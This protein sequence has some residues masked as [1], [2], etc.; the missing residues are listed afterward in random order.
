MKATQYGAATA[1][2]VTAFARKRRDKIRQPVAN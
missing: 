1:M 2:A